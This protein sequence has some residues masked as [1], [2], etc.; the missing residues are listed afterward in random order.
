MKYEIVMTH[1]QGFYDR[2]IL[3]K[4]KVE[5]FCRCTEGVPD[6][7]VPASDAP[8]QVKSHKLRERTENRELIETVVTITIGR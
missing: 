6:V 8:G 5:C 3:G 1:R 4:A 2:M 7:P